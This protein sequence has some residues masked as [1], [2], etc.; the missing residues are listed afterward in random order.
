MCGKRLEQGED[1]RYVL[2]IEVYAA[3]DP[4]ELGAEDLEEDHTEEMEDLLEE[5]E[6]VPAE[7][8]ESEVYRTYRFDL[9]PECHAAYLKDPLGR[10][11][12]LKARF[13]EN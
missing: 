5:M 1:T 9:C 10:G 3:Y 4:L 13:G 8:L 11:A 12:R 2:K 7:D 6:D